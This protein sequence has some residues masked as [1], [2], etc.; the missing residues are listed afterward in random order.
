[1]R[2]TGFE[3]IT[4]PLDENPFEEIRALCYEIR[5]TDRN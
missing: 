2:W 5:I 1:M 3:T 4:F